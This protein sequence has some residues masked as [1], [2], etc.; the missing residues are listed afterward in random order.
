[1]RGTQ[2]FTVGVG[3]VSEGSSR[4]YC[5]SRWSL[6]KELNSLLYKL[7]ES[8]RGAQEFTVG[9]GGVN[10]SSNIAEALQYLGSPSKRLNTLL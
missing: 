3:G 8:V 5:R 10:L 6:W 1:M 4:V 9:V 7:V 2:Q